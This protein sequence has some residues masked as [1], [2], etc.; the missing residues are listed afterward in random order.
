MRL[1]QRLQRQAGQKALVDDIPFDLPVQS[2]NSP[3]L[4]AAFPANYERARALL[5]GR[6]L[7]PIKFRGKAILVV[8]VIDYRETS[9]GA[10]IEYSIGLGCTFGPK[11]VPL[12]PAIL[13]RGHFGLGQYVID[14]PVSSEISVKGGK[15]I[16]GMPKHQANL[17]FEIGDRSVRSRYDK[18]GRMVAEIQ[19]DIPTQIRFPIGTSGVN[20]CAFRG[21]L[22]KSSIYFR[23]RGH[24]GLFSKANATFTLGDSDRADA[25]RDLEI[26][27]NALFT[28]FFPETNGTP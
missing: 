10:Y 6:E 16:W 23:G 26:G 22:M 2:R 19:I 24:F 14:L 27:K 11:P 15:G 21:M 13:F 1:P 7:H 4:M 3:A 8:A 20:W 28:A 17:D 9:I 18:D 5:P 25:L 12:L